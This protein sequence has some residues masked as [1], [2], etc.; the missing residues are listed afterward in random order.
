MTSMTHQ[1]RT[2]INAQL[3]ALEVLENFVP[4]QGREMLRNAQSASKLLR[5]VVEDMLDYLRLQS[6]TMQFNRSVFA[7]RS[8]VVELEEIFAS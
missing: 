3:T 1:F 6:G 2:P 4:P 5:A 8:L 7:F